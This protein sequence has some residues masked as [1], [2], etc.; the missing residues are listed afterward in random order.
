MLKLLKKCFF[1]LWPPYEAYLA[2]KLIDTNTSGCPKQRLECIQRDI[3][4]SLPA[5]TDLN[6]AEP[7]AKLI[8]E[9]EA[10]RK[11]T[12]ENKALAFMF[13]FSV[14]VSVIS[15]IPAV[16]GEKWN[17]T[18]YAAIVCVGFYGLAILHLL[19]AVYYAIQARRISGLALPS[20]DESLDA[21]KENRLTETDK[22]VM[23]ISQAKFNEPILTKK[24][25]SLAV[26]EKMF[27]RG[28][29]LLAIAS[30]IA[31][32]AKFFVGQAVSAKHR[33]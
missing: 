25:N 28:L 31:V 10:K 13:A 7:L 32:A 18:L 24:A 27:I 17:I 2:R 22:I 14:S 20:A 23:Y 1:L 30:G 8:F 33:T 6:K 12:I 9:S 16:F 3:R 4:K 29:I 11:E 5:T 26:A 21:I 15:I 19:I